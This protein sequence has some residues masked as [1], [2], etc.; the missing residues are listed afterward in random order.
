MI[1]Y[2]RNGIVDIDDVDKDETDKFVMNNKASPKP[3]VVEKGV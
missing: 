3:I 2:V 1:D